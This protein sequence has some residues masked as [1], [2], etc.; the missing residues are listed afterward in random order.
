[1]AVL[2]IFGCVWAHD[3][4]AMLTGK[5]LRG[6]RL[7]P[8][9][10]PNKTWAGLAGGLVASACLGVAFAQLLANE[11]PLT[12]A[13][14]GLALGVA[15]FVGDLLESALKRRYGVKNASNLIPGHGGFLDRMDGI[16][17]AA[18]AAVGIALLVNSASPAAGLLFLR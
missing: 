3:T 10:S 15:A 2:F 5:A 11:R 17:T 7:W 1:M 6:P 8:S 12:M 4:F 13:A 14:I 16:V 9:L 18:I